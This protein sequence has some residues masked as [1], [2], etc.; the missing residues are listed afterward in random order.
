LNASSLSIVG[1]VSI[2]TELVSVKTSVM[3]INFV[4]RG[5]EVVGGAGVVT[6]AGVVE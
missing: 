2:D 3:Q 5:I 4:L 1:S 6:R